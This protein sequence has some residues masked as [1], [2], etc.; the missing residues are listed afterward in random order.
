M[1]NEELLIELETLVSAMEDSLAVIAG[2][3]AEVAG[4]AATLGHLVAGRHGMEVSH[5]PNEWRDRLLR[6]AARIV[7]LKARPHAANDPALQDLI[8][9][10][11]QGPHKKSG[12]H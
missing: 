9:R 11:L 7:A 8:A 2:T 6:S 12:M 1:T 3:I 4:P 10:V 5:G